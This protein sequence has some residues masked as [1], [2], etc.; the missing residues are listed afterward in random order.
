MKDLSAGAS[1]KEDDR[2]QMTVDRLQS[3]LTI[4][5]IKNLHQDDQDWNILPQYHN[6]L[7]P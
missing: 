4:F 7:I 1:A 5:R 2:L 3:S 6:T